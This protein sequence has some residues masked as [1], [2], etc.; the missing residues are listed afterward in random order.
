MGNEAS[1]V[2][3]INPATGEVF[4]ETK[5]STQEEVN[6]AVQKAKE[7]YPKWSGLS[8]EERK[9]Y[10]A[11]AAEAV[12]ASTKE[13]AELITK[14]QGKPL[15]PGGPGSL[16]EAGACSTWIEANLAH[17]LE[18]EV[19]VEDDTM[20]AELHR[21][22]LGVFGIITPWNWPTIISTWCV[23]PALRTGNTVVLKPSEYTTQCVVEL[24]KTINSVLPEGVL[25]V[26]IGDGS[27]GAM[28]TGHPDLAKIVFTGST[29]T[30]K[31]IAEAASKSLARVTLECGGN[32]AGILLKGTKMEGP[33]AMDLFWGCMLNSGQTCAVI[34]RLYVHEDDVDRITNALDEI[35]GSMKMGNGLE[36]GT[37][38]GPLSNKMQYDI[39]VDLVEDAK[40]NGGK[41]IRGGSPMPDT[42]GYFFPVTIITGLDNGSKL[43]D[44]EQF[45]PVIVII[46]YK[47]ID[48]AVTKANDSKSA[49]GASVWGDDLKEAQAVGSRL[50]AGTVWINQHAALHP[51]V[52][53]GGVKD[54]GYGVES[55]ALGLLGT[56]ATKVI[57]IKKA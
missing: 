41:I 2:K 55:G 8:D 14:E 13:L 54:S 27:V 32:D 51:L 4:A 30:G 19:L 15:F 39:V 21:V 43:V 49:L 35:A 42:K 23:I 29:R 26:V 18:P 56:T 46:S 11:K 17:K 22:S 47:T 25:N 38:L 31:K 45:G 33:R 52:P 1:T 5:M 16:F 57:N 28:L 40:K 7:A 24:I 36:E 9:S 44:N 34:K 6:A 3:S 53:F 48:E 10:L 37:L 50:V 12:K 20:R